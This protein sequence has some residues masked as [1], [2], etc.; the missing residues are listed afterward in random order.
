MP[1][2]VTQIGDKEIS[3]NIMSGADPIDVS[4]VAPV[5][6]VE[7]AK[8]AATPVTEGASQVDIPDMDK[9]GSAHMEV[10]KDDKTTLDDFLN[11]KNGIKL[12]EPDKKLDDKKV[13]EVP[14][15]EEVKKE[16]SKTEV[17]PEV[18][19]EA[20]K[21]EIPKDGRDYSD[22]PTDYV[23]HFKRMHNNQFNALK[24]AIK[25]LVAIK[26]DKV[27]LETEVTELRKGGLPQSYYENPVGYVLDTGYQSE[28]QKQQTY[29]SFLNHWQEQLANIEAG[30]EFTT[31]VADGKGGFAQSVPRAATPQDKA[32][33]LTNL[34]H[35]NAE[36]NKA[37]ANADVIANTFTARHKQD[38]SIVDDFD[39]K[40]FVEINKNIKDYQPVIDKLKAAIPPSMRSHKLADITA[41][42]TMAMLRYQK[43]YNDLLA[44]NGKA[45]QAAVTKKEDK[46]K[47][48][49]TSAELGVATTVSTKE[50]NMDDFAKLKAGY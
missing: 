48:G 13:E 31:I 18:K 34:M 27:K 6:P 17:V 14:K 1:I 20:A 25:E 33:V 2:P 12:P 40:Y 21:V 24:P 42:M 26:A 19:K 9:R 23:E 49:P 44:A 35:C 4:P 37:K 8:P 47:G 38:I 22:I 7:P 30:K 5:V 46:A 45:T 50:V 41:K 3:D 32:A 11:I 29:S 16:E 39:N 15:V 10:A 43:A 28:V 36:A